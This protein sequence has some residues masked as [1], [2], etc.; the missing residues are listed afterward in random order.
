VDDDPHSVSD[1]LA[2]AACLREALRQK[3]VPVALSLMTDDVV[4]V[5]SVGPPIAGLDSV[6]AALSSNPVTLE[7]RGRGRDPRPHR[8]GARHRRHSDEPPINGH[9]SRESCHPH[10]HHAGP[11]DRDLPAAGGRLE[12]CQVHQF[13]GAGQSPALRL[14][15]SLRLPPSHCY[16]YAYD[17]GSCSRSRSGCVGASREHRVTLS[18]FFA[19]FRTPCSF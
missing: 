5:G 3:D 6:R 17:S 10:G 19:L 2:V 7:V 12:A 16:D 15:E 1:V 8:G 13:I 9:H 11:R 14:G 4:F 18:V